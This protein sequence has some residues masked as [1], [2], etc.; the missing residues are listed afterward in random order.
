MCPVLKSRQPAIEK[1]Q[2]LPDT[3]TVTRSQTCGTEGPIEV[4]PTEGR[5]SPAPSALL[6]KPYLEGCVA[7]GISF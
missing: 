4:I 3:V 7:L 6:V 5:T 2:Y 1:L